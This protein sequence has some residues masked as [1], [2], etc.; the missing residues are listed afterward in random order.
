LSAE[1]TPLPQRGDDRGAVYLQSFAVRYEYPVHFTEHLF[2]HD[3]PVFRDTLLKRE[4]GRRH[5]FVV[6][7]DANVAA[8]FPSLE[9]D[10]AGYAGVHADAM[11]LVAHPEAIPGGEQVKNDPAWPS[12]S[13]SAAARFS[14]WSDMPPRPPIAASAMCACRPRCW[15][16]T[17]RASA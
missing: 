4:P 3:N 1:I 13:A 15:R 5:R 7:I 10:I 6:F 9:H 14:T 17:T 2:T 16:R 12:S 8:S 11:E